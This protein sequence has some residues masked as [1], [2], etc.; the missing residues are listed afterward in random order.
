MQ[1]ENSYEISLDEKAHV[2]RIT[3][4]GFWNDDVL[5][6]YARDMEDALKRLRSLSGQ[7]GLV[8]DIREMKAQSQETQNRLAELEERLSNLAPSRTALLVQPGLVKLQA[9]RYATERARMFE[10]EEEAISWIGGL[11]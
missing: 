1:G 10:S 5:D 7:T 11:R 2:L 4:R 8:I 9:E 6:G 3:Q